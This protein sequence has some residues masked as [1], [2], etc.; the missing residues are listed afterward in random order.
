MKTIIGLSDYDLG[1]ESG[2]RKYSK[3]LYTVYGL[4][5]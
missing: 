2:H 1:S 3:G 5:G 4:V